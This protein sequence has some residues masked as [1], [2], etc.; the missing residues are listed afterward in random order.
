MSLLTFGN[1]YY[2]AGCEIKNIL[3]ESLKVVD[4]ILDKFDVSEGF[5]LINHILL[6]NRF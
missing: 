5:L 3:V 2:P 6:L 1:T 4:L